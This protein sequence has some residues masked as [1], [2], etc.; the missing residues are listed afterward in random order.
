MTCRLVVRSVKGAIC[1]LL[2]ILFFTMITS[3]YS[4]ENSSNLSNSNILPPIKIWHGSSESLIQGQTNPWQTDAEKSGLTDTPNYSKTINYIKRL[5]ASTSKLQM[6]SLGKS[7]QGRDIWMVIASK[8]GVNNAKSMLK[9]KRPTLLVQAG[10]H[11]GEIDGKDA[12]LMLLRDIVHGNK[13]YLIDNVNML[14]I[15]ILSVDAHERRSSSNRVNQRGPTHMGWRTNAENLNL[16]RDYT[17]LETLELKYVIQAINRWQPDLYFDVHV[18]DGTDYQ[19]DITYGFNLSYSESP[20]I[21]KWLTENFQPVIDQSLSDKGHKG[22]PLVFGVDPMDFSKGIVGWSASPRFSNGYGDFRQLPTV[23]LENHSLKSYRQRVLGTY[24]FLEATLKLLA[25]KGESLTQATRRDKNRRP[26]QMVVAW[27]TNQESPEQMDFQGIDFHQSKDSVTGLDYV[28]WLGKPRLYK[29]LPI[30]RMNKPKQSVDIPKYYWIP[31]QYHQVIEKLRLHGIKM[32]RIK[33]KIVEVTE[34]EAFDYKFNPQPFE[35]RQMV[36]S[37][38]TTH[39]KQV[40]LPKHTVRVATDQDLGR[41]AVALLDPR[42]PDSLFAWGYFNSIFQRTEYIES[43]ALIPL[44]KQLF[45]TNKNLQIEFEN[46]K[47]NEPKFVKD[48]KSQMQWIYKHSAYYDKHFLKY[49]VLISQ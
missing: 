40:K 34:M 9:L 8:E 29:D 23:L 2:T 38:F 36:T 27:Q 41:L 30:Y 24:V 37:H 25:E 5:V 17:K 44:A 6:I 28:Q 7:P 12:G 21:S 13:G 18:T 11:S 31:P 45:S 4:K 43:Y 26:E 35:G 32:I 48:Q 10:I 49:P 1:F 46:K 20:N 14:F 22:G 3:V 15:P 33:P 47:K 39:K 19:Y 42:A 16:N